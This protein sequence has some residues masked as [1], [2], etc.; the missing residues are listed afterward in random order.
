MSQ[1]R[2][3]R[4]W[5]QIALQ[6]LLMRSDWRYRLELTLYRISHPAWIGMTKLTHWL[7]ALDGKLLKWAYARHQQRPQAEKEKP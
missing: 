4:R 6:A 1:S 2:H 7:S 5:R 3:A